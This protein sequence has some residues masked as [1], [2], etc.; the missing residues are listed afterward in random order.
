MLYICKEKLTNQRLWQLGLSL[1]T[2]LSFQRAKSFFKNFNYLFLN[3]IFSVDYILDVLRLTFK[4]SAN[5]PWI[6]DITTCCVS[7]CRTQISKYTHVSH[8]RFHHQSTLIL[9]LS[10]SF[11]VSTFICFNFLDI[12]CMYFDVF[13]LRYLE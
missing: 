3:Y 12:C 5:V 8:V 11:M 2:I 9:P 6:F 13:I 10:S 7:F 1:R 4:A